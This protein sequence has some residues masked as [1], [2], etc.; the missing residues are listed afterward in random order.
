MQFVTAVLPS[1]TQS[2][3]YVLADMAVEQ[4]VLFTCYGGIQTH[5]HASL[6]SPHCSGSKRLRKTQTT[7]FLKTVTRFNF[8][9]RQVVS[10]EAAW[11]ASGA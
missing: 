5:T 11:R 2:L 1:E 8:N 3:H 9:E 4:H 6:P 7:S 10:V